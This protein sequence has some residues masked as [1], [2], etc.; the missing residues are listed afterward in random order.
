MCDMKLVIVLTYKLHLLKTL[1]QFTQVTAMYFSS[2]SFQFGLANFHPLAY[3]P[4]SHDSYQLGVE[5]TCAS[6]EGR[7]EN[8]HF[9]RNCCSWWV[10]GQRNIWRK[11]LSTHVCIHELTGTHSWLVSL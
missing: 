7:E 3:S 6:C 9:F 11:V 8:L 10:T 4:L 2:F 1:V 5:Q